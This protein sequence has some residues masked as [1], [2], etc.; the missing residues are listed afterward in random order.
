MAAKSKKSRQEL[1]QRLGMDLGR[2]LS[3]NNVFFHEL[4]ARKFGL[5]A[6]DM[7]C[8]DLIAHAGANEL[9]AG[10]LGRATG[11][12]TGAITGILDR[13]EA[14]ALVARIRD[15][16]DR[17]RVIVRPRPEA[18]SRVAKLYESLG[19]AMMKLAASYTTAELEIISDFLERDLAILK[20]QIARLS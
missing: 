16:I 10:D 5:N 18:V 14:A 3:D 15:A 17:R 12:T 19:E 9:T 20:D 2:E 11:L 8:L 4:V 13:L 1:L 7:R 6:T